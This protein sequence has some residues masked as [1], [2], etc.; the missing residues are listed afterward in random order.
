MPHDPNPSAQDFLSAFSDPRTVA[1]YIDGPP[2]FLPGL[3]ALHRMTGILLAERAPKDATILVLGAGGGMELKALAEAH[4]GW[5]FVGVDPSREM[6][7]LA[8]STLGALGERVELIEGYIEDAP[9]GPFDGATCLLT[10]H[11]LSAAERLRT[12]QAI[13]RRL[14][15]AAPLVAAHGSFPQDDDGERERWIARYAAF[16]L[17]SGADPDKVQFAKAAVASGTTMLAPSQDEAILSR[18]GFRDVQLFYAAFTWR[19]WVAYA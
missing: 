2:R 8:R 6:L 14:K 17:A 11:F 7:G 5:R 4:A 10:L 13:H 16:G 1:R 9:A 15:S 18:A 19:G 12:L 3:D